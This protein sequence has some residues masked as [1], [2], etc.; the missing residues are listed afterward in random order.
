[1]PLNKKVFAEISKWLLGR[2]A[3][4]LPGFIR[5]RVRKVLKA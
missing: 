3:N 5:K 2:F 4:K 1:M